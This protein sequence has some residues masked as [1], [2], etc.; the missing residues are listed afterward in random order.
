MNCEALETA[1]LLFTWSHD[2]LKLYRITFYFRKNVTS[3]QPILASARTKRDAIR[4]ARAFVATHYPGR[5]VLEDDQEICR[6]P[7]DVLDWN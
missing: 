7:D 5:V 4:R 3:L 1:P 6:T 2:M